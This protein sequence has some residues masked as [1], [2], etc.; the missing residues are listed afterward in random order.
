MLLHEII[1]EAKNRYPDCIAVESNAG[2][3]TY[4]NLDRISTCL[5]IHLL[6]VGVHKYDRVA[7][8]LNKSI[9][10]IIVFL[11]VLKSG[12]CY[13]PLDVSAPRERISYILNDAQAKCIVTDFKHLQ[14]AKAVKNKEIDIVVLDDS[15]NETENNDEDYTFYYRDIVVNEKEVTE[16][17]FNIK[18]EGEDL[19][20]ILYTSGSTGQPKGVAISHKNSVCFINWAY[21]YFGISPQDVLSSHAPFYFDLSVFDIYVSI[22]AGAKLCLLPPAVSSF[23]VSLASY[24][25]DKGITVWYSVPSVLVQLLNY[26]N[27]SNLNLS[28]LHTIIYAGE[29][30]PVARLN[31]LMKTLPKADFFN[32]YGPTETNVITYY[33]IKHIDSMEEIPIGYACPYARLWV[34]KENGSLAKV[35]EKGE[36]LV[37]SESLMKGYYKK[38]NLTENVINAEKA[39]GLPHGMYYHTGDIVKVVGEGLYQFICRK[40]RMIKIKGFR[41]ELEEIEAILRKNPL[42][43]ECIVQQAG[44]D[45]KEPH[46]RAYVVSNLKPKEIIGFAKRYLPEYMIPDDIQYVKEFDYTDRGKINRNVAV[47]KL[48]WGNADGIM[49]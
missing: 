8:L 47:E 31:E 46:L 37:Q 20:Y 6:K 36:L 15:S 49:E 42:I 33:P 32:L 44:D 4:E 26:G 38:E 29:A 7:V 43:K 16:F 30:F 39:D 11:G 34:L 24:I 9:E 23:P 12:A 13:V 18:T 22:K 2:N 17:L 28:R 19:A 45:K 48:C 5:A 27:L 25:A 40:D 3:I 1:T 10:A 41:V 35:G 14:Q 21:D